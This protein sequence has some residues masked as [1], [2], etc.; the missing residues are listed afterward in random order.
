MRLHLRAGQLNEAELEVQ[1]LRAALEDALQ[2]ASRAEAE[3]ERI[4][5]ICGKMEANACEQ[6]ERVKVRGVVSFLP[7]HTTDH[8]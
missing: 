4:S 2:K 7:L 6:D 8:G 1:T 3:H 5:Q